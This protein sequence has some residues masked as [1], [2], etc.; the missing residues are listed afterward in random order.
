MLTISMPLPYV[1][2]GDKNI[3]LLMILGRPVNCLFMK[4]TG[5]VFCLQTHF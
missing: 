3:T 5:G 4:N 1:V 2:D